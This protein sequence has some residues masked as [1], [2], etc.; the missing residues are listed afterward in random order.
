MAVEQRIHLLAAG[1]A[2]EDLAERRLEDGRLGHGRF[3][4]E[5]SAAGAPIAFLSAL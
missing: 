1:D 3:L 5:M 4:S 2:L